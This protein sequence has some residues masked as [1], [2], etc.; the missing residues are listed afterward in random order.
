MSIKSNYYAYKPFQLLFKYRNE[1]LF[2][3]RTD[4]L[5]QM[6][7]R[8]KFKDFTVLTIAHRLDT[9]MDSDRIMLLDAGHL[10]VYSFF[11]HR[12]D[13]DISL[14]CYFRNLMNRQFY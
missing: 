14:K 1:L 11:L 3:Y 12:F 2:T 9:I 6:T 7:I 10:T 8:E 4:A 5:I 13:L